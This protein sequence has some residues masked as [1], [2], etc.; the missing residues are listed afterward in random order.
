MGKKHISLSVIV[1]T[2][3]EFEV[4]DFMVATL[5]Q[6]LDIYNLE[7]VVVDDASTD[8]TQQKLKIL[9]EIYPQLKIVHR[10]F[11]RSLGKS[12]GA[13]IARSTGDFICIMDADLTHNPVY[14]HQMLVRLVGKEYSVG[15]RF[16]SGGSMPNKFHYYSSKCFNLFLKKLLNTQV[17]DNLSGFIVFKREG[18]INP[19]DDSVFF[20]Y[21]DFFFRLIV[22]L[23][24]LGFRPN[25]IPIVYRNRSAGQSKS[26]FTKLLFKYTWAAL[27]FRTK[28]RP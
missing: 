8:G 20:G 12:I 19:S 11:D 6:E 28:L 21:G 18:Y 17:S 13:G 10:L 4:V 2:Y 27:A 23:N 1:P 3:N 26:N 24:S 9:A 5:V 16:C 7:I 15:S 22:H 25:E 14:I